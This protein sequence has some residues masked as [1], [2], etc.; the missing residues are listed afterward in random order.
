MNN[1]K[2]ILM[3]LGMHRSGTSVA[4]RMFNFLGADPGG[5]ML[6]SGEDNPQGFWEPR[7][8]VHLHDELLEYLGY[9]WNDSRPLQYKWW[10]HEGVKKYEDK[11]FDLAEKSYSDVQFP[12]LKDPRLCRLMPVW[13]N[14]LKRL[15]WTGKFILVG[16]SPLDVASSLATR[17][18][19]SFQHSFLL[20]LRYV[21]ESEMWSRDH[22]RAFLLYEQLFD[23]WE[24][25]IIKCS[26]QINFESKSLTDKIKGEIDSFIDVDLR[27]HHASAKDHKKIPRAIS[28]L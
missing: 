14:V 2:S 6:E 9:S 10:E 23:G 18:G 4:T 16:R 24:D 8:I 25:S 21:V 20:W 22:P 28:I 17:N 15:G 13:S 5:D 11:L 1:K 19:F 3:I 27:H 26:N 12:L 7:E